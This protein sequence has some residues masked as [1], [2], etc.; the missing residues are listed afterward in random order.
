MNEAAVTRLLSFGPHNQQAVVA[1][2]HAV[3][4]AGCSH[5]VQ[6]TDCNQPRASLLQQQ[7]GPVIPFGFAR[8]DLAARSLHRVSSC[9]GPAIMLQMTALLVSQV[10]V[11][12]ACIGRVPQVT[13]CAVQMKACMEEPMSEAA[14]TPGD[15]SDLSGSQL[16]EV[17]RVSGS[18]APLGMGRSKSTRERRRCRLECLR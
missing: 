11:T 14:V 9:T 10:L 13:H 6:A 1:Q 15:L 17:R 4:A 16:Q 18:R 5:A 12:A 7:Q 8:S 2:S 3:G